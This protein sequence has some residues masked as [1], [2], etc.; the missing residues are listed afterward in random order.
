M[1]LLVNEPNCNKSSSG[2][3]NGFF[4]NFKHNFTLNGPIP[5]RGKWAK[6]V[7]NN[8]RHLYIP[9]FNWNDNQNPGIWVNP[10]PTGQNKLDRRNRG[11]VFNSWLHPEKLGWHFKKYVNNFYKGIPP[12]EDCQ[13]CDDVKWFLKIAWKYLNYYQRYVCLLFATG[14]YFVC[15]CFA[16]SWFVWRQYQDWSWW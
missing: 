1:V 15:F 10:I 8:K 4:N 6:L 14:T 2:F 13:I 5:N 7:R 9:V 12:A 11:P 3:C 16:W